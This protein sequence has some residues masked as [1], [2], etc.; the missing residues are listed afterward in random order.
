[1]PATAH[2]A[3][4]G[5]GAAYMPQPTVAT[6]ACVKDCASKK[7]I[8]GGSLAKISGQ[9]LASVTKVVFQGSGTKAAAKAASVKSHND[10]AV[11][12]AVPIDAQT[13]PVQAL[14]SGGVQ[15]PPS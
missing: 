2:A 3:T 11:V 5:G 4:N 1:M 13:G 12:V 7:R 9:N 10:S 15:S 6:V 8:Q 14:A